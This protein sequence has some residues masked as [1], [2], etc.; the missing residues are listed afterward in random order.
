MPMTMGGLETARPLNILGFDQVAQECW[1]DCFQRIREAERGR[2]RNAGSDW[3]DIVNG[4]S[5]V[6]MTT[7]SIDLGH[8]E[9]PMLPQ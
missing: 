3:N 2:W 9:A 7:C 6:I 8:R 4:T 5:P 1:Q